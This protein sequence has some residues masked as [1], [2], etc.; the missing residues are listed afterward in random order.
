M[1]RQVR[2]RRQSWGEG[3][4]HLDSAGRTEE[5]QERE[6]GRKT[7]PTRSAWKSEKD[8]PRARMAGSGREVPSST[9]QLGRFSREGDQVSARVL[10][11]LLGDGG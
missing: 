11:L 4:I 8:G 10:T 5:E 2:R 6:K 9:P 3:V 7:Q 1:D